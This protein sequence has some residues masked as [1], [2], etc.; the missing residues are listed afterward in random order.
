MFVPSVDRNK[1]VGVKQGLSSRRRRRH[2]QFDPKRDETQ[3][4]LVHVGTGAPSWPARRR[5][6]RDVDAVRGAAAVACRGPHH[7]GST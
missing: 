6:R 7:D 1:K 5:R 2:I 3:Q 4:I